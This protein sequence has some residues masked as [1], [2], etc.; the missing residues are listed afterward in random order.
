MASKVVI[1][2]LLIIIL[3]TNVFLFITKI[4]ELNLFV[5]FSITVLIF[6]ALNIAEMKKIKKAEEPEKKETTPE[7]P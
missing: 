1:V 2:T 3:L 6:I 4:L 5:L 7:Q